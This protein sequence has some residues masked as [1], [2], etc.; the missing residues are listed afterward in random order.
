MI[1]LHLNTVL[2]SRGYCEMI[3]S[4]WI[5][6]EQRYQNFLK[7]AGELCDIIA[8]LRSEF[9]HTASASVKIELEREI[10]VKEDRYRECE[11]ELD[12]YKKKINLHEKIAEN[13]LDES[14]DFEY[15]QS[16]Q[17]NSEQVIEESFNTTSM[18]IN[19]LQKE[20]IREHKF[21]FD[22]SR[23]IQASSLITDDEIK[24]T[25]LY[26]VTFFPGLSIGDFDQVVTFLLE[27][28]TKE[29][30]NISKVVDDQGESKIVEEKESKRL[31]DLW[32]SPNT[33]TYKDEILS[34][35]YIE[36]QII[37]NSLQQVI[38]F[39]SSHSYLRDELFQ[40]FGKSVFYSRNKFQKVQSL[41]LSPSEKIVANAIKIA[42]NISI[43]DPNLYG[44]KFLLE[45]ISKLGENEEHKLFRTAL[46][47]LVSEQ[48]FEQTKYSIEAQFQ[49]SE[50]LKC[51]ICER[52]AALIYEMEKN[53]D[54]KGVS[55]NFLKQ[56][57][58]PPLNRYDVVLEICKYLKTSM[59]FDEIYWIKQILSRGDVKNR[60]K[61]Y[62]F[63]LTLLKQSKNLYGKLKSIEEWL[64]IASKNPEDYSPLHKYALQLFVEYS[65][66]QSSNLKLEYY[67]EYPSRHSIFYHLQYGE[68]ES[69]LDILVNFLFCL[70]VDKNKKYH[71]ER[72]ALSYIVD[73]DVN[74]MNLIGFL[75]AQ[76]YFI[77]CGLKKK[78]LDPKASQI[79]EKLLNKIICKLTPFLRKELIKS[80]ANF[81]H[82]LRSEAKENKKVKEEYLVKYN[83]VKQ[84]KDK[85]ISLDKSSIQIGAIVS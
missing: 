85:F 22:T 50:K 66:A 19:E 18:V 84:L 30:I 23:C 43:S 42:V 81:C 76:W 68:I 58:A 36:I 27:D 6:D 25:V 57:M 31:L 9:N 12:L 74:A 24:N 56:V 78:N 79:F 72:L 63:L 1:V 62:Q 67:G 52:L 15:N 54:L 40:F 4:T 26:V 83:L 33:P 38:D 82:Y 77:L 10:K 2:N 73:K 3:T 69:K 46:S 59:E 60:D 48:S 39:S 47:G 75:I 53:A 20:N 45:I 80:W 7:E 64:P 32:N 41:I 61:A 17:E 29:F 71:S 44:G 8:K 65:L 51:F 14:R 5:F 28:K 55:N 11:K 70:Y 34:Q 49:E 13:S 35:C 21:S 37:P 16:N